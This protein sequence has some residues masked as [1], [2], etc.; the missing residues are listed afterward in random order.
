MTA[1]DGI[2]HYDK[3]KHGETVTCITCLK[4]IGKNNNKY[5]IG[6][7]YLCGDCSNKLLKPYNSGKNRLKNH[8]SDKK[9]VYR[10]IDY[11]DFEDI[12]CTDCGKNILVYGKAYLNYQPSKDTEKYYCKNCWKTIQAAQKL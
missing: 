12:K 1:K 6:S 10:K 11:P 2:G 3:N 8:K 9:G 7:N 4:Q 5:K